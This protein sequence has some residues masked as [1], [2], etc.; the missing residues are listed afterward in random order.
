METAHPTQ[1]EENGVGEVY[2]DIIVQNALKPEKQLQFR[3]LVDTGAANL[4]LPSAWRAQLGDLFYESLELETATQAK[5]KG[6]ICG[7]VRITIDQFRPISSEVVFIDMEPGKDGGYEPLLGFIPL[8][9]TG[10]AVDMLR[11]KLVKL[12]YM[13]LK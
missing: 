7:P 5:V 2:A 4:T 3:A 10:L 9:Q 6:D 11:H 8:E 1:H 13:P 12:K